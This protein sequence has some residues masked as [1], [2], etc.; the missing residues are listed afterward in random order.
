MEPKPSASEQISPWGQARFDIATEQVDRIFGQSD[1]MGDPVAVLPYERYSEIPDAVIQGLRERGLIE[2][3]NFDQIEEVRR[4][5][6]SAFSL[7]AYG[8]EP[9]PES[10]ASVTPMNVNSMVNGTLYVC[11]F[12]RLLKS[13]EK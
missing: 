4:D 6:L 1:E 13:E 11:R 8:E 10:T 7:A 2:E 3:L 9:R 5:A 12:K